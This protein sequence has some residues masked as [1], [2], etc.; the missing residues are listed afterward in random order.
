MAT[1]KISSNITA[2][3]APLLPRNTSSGALDPNDYGPEELRDIS[4]LGL[5]GM[6]R[7]MR[8]R[9]YTLRH[10]YIKIG[11][12]LK[13]SVSLISDG[14]GPQRAY[15]DMCK[16]YLRK[17]KENLNPRFFRRPSVYFC[18]SMLD[19]AAS[20]LIWLYTDDTVKFR[21]R[22]VKEQIKDLKDA[23]DVTRPIVIL[24]EKVNVRCQQAVLADA[25]EYFSRQEQQ[26]LL[27]DSL[28]VSRLRRLQVYMAMALVFLVFA[29]V[30]AAPKGPINSGPGLTWPAMQVGP[31]WLTQLIAAV[32][33]GA[34]GAAGGFFSGLINTRDS[35]TTLGEYRTNML[36][37]ALKPL[38]G[39]VASVILYI[40]LDWQ[41]TGVRIVNGG[42]FL[43]IGFLAGF[44]ERYF[45]KV[46]Q[47]QAPSED[48]DQQKMQRQDRLAS[49]RDQLVS[50]IAGSPLPPSNANGRTRFGGAGLWWPTGVSASITGGRVWKL[51]AR[52]R[53]AR[54][55]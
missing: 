40:F 39:A 17:A 53:N 18:S 12:D 13:V 29:T 31:P 14:S 25:L 49:V 43:L 46:V 44:S 47:V 7:Y 48:N 51:A 11:N 1:I 30:V 3:Q 20:S 33:V 38:V 35:S 45:L 42:T 27:E 24:D 10:E 50:T 52:A 19:L 55:A 34:L 41:V 6:R 2:E 16:D 36:K 37:L 5:L 15:A 22:A 26:L 28:Q 21:S 23:D 54:R 9:L 8:S 32:A 4:W